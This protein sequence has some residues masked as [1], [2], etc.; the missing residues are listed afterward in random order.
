MKT[1]AVSGPDRLA[2]RVGVVAR[3]GGEAARKRPEAVVVGET[4]GR[5]ERAQGAAVEAAVEADDLRVD[6][7]AG[8]GVLA[9]ELDRALRRLRARVAEEDLAAEARLAQALGQAQRG[10]GEEQVGRAGER[11]G[12]LLD[13]GDDPRV[14]VAGVVD[15]EPGEEVQV[16]LAVRVPQ[17][18]ALAAHELD[19]R[20]QVRRHRVAR[21][22]V[23]RGVTA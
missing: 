14:T 4:R 8:A 11:T 5:R 21:L 10:L 7:V 23:A 15:R 2:Q 18:R 13:R 6:V 17:P 16:L 19:L 3:D 20:A 22:Q 12:L 9:R 1:A